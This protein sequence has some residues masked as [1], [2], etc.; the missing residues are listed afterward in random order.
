[1]SLKLRLNLI[2]TALL[3]LMMAIGAWFMLMNAREDVR[4]EIEST[5]GLAL[6]LLDTEILSFAVVPIGGPDATPFRLASLS[7]IRHLRIEFYD[8]AGKLRDSNASNS[9]PDE[10]HTTPQWFVHLMTTMSPSWDKTRR[11]VLFGGR[12]IGELVV[13]PDP[14]Y[15]IAEVWSDIKGILGLAFIFFIA[16]NILVYWAV[17]KALRPVEGIL[18][19][20]EDL[21]HGKLDTRLPAFKLPELARISVKFNGMAQTLQQSILRNLGLSKQLISLQERERKNLARDLHD[22]I[23]QSITAIHVDAQAIVSSN[24]NSASAKASVKQSATA[25]VK[26]T[27][28]M[29]DMTHQIL[30][31]LRPDALDKFGLEVALSELIASWRPRLNGASCVIKIS[32]ELN[33]LPEVVS[34]TVYRVVQES[35]T[36]IARYASARRVTIGVLQEEDTVVVMVED[37]GCGF[38]TSSN[39]NGFGL[40]GMRER[41]EGLGGEFELDSALGNGTQVVVRLPLFLKE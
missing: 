33:G 7:H 8:V 41:I 1:M 39:S 10:A 29:M 16:V 38:D 30:E 23:G 21:E 15:E 40:A 6:H 32:G 13:T 11:S 12:L 5:A 14:S 17:D 37:D 36:N 26:V 20:L 4:A 9:T 31:R 34:I 24:L 28:Q 25:I 2:I 35:L 3:L 22:E 18:L 27:E 19:A